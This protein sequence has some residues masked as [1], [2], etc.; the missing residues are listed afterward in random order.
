[1]KAVA[2]PIKRLAHGA[3]LPL[4]AAATPLSAGFDL[5]AAVASPL[6]LE[7]MERALVPTGC[8]IA[9]P[10]GYEAQLR[11]R[12]GLALHHG[13]TVLNAPG[14]IDADYR[15]EIGVVLVNLGRDPFTIERGQR[16][17]QLV[18]APFVT[19]LWD[20]CAELPED[21][22]RGSGGFGSTG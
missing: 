4:P 11:P 1:M 7:P 16:V 9:L 5:C 13:I 21:R 6:V 17:A 3:D 22:G 15:G 20:E 8:S 14:T 19:A 10:A 18:V 12:S 2:I